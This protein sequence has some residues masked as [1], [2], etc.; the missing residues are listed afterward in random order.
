MHLI[1][2]GA[3]CRKYITSNGGFWWSEKSLE[4]T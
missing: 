2:H 1:E 3:S 4:I